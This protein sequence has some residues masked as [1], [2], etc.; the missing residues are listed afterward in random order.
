MDH[1]FK[2]TATPTD[3]RAHVAACVRKLTDVDGERGDVL[4]GAEQPYWGVLI[5]GGGGIIR[6]RHLPYDED[7]EEAGINLIS[8]WE[9]IL[10]PWFSGKAKMNYRRLRERA[11]FPV[12]DGERRSDTNPH[13]IV[14]TKEKGA[15]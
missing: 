10:E 1:G 8:A 14:W 7:E 12:P 15:L 9:Q 13:I 2:E 5:A 3:V 11:G 4:V 6:A